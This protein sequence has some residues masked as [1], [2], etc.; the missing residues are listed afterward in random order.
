MARTA[1]RTTKPARVGP[2]S[3]PNPLRPAEAVILGITRES[4]NTNTY[5]LAFKDETLRETYRFSPGQFN[6]VG[7]LGYGE[8]PISVS[9]SPDV[10][11]T[12]QH[13]VRILGDVTQAIGRLEKGDALGVRGPYGRGW[14]IEEARGKDVL[15]VAGGLGIAPLRP[16]IEHVL[17]HP[18]DFGRLT[19]LYGGRTPD[20][21]IY[22]RY[23]ERWSR[24]P[25]STLLVTVDRLN[26]AH[27]PWTLNVGV[28][29]TLL[30]KT[31]LFPQ[32]SLVMIAGPQVMMRFTLVDLLKRGF[33]PDR[34]FLTMERRMECG[35]AQCGHCYLGPKYVCKD[36]PVFRYAEISRLLAVEGI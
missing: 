13:T 26:G 5:T 4:H 20:D 9:S 35:V 24:S 12:F 10:S 6:Q 14:P 33:S 31:E 22:C 2:V 15:I 8:A 36:G 1:P 34:L 32:S 23:Y 7:I 25:N 3:R 16:A 19:I 28:V 17:Q 29:P 27:E 18:A 11:G 21:L 30:E